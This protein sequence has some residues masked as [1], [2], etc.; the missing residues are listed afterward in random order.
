M[1]FSFLHNNDNEYDTMVIVI[2]PKLKFFINPLNV[3]RI[4]PVHKLLITNNKY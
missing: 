4:L 2:I 3:I 1:Y